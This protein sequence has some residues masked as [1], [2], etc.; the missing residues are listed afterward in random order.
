MPTTVSTSTVTSTE[1]EEDGEEE[2]EEEEEERRFHDIGMTIGSTASVR[3][4][5]PV[6]A[7]FFFLHRHNYRVNRLCTH[8]GSRP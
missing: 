7:T 2:E 5:V 6:L 1:E 8:W 3:T 4:V